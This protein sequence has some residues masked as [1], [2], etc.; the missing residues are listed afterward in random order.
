MFNYSFVFYD[1]NII[2]NLEEK[3]QKR[4]Y[5]KCSPWSSSAN[6]LLLVSNEKYRN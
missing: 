1:C 6:C 2:R 4:L 3:V 5:S